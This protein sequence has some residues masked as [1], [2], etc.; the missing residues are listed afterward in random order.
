MCGTEG[1]CLNQTQHDLLLE[2]HGPIGFPQSQVQGKGK[3]RTRKTK[4]KL[5]CIWFG[6]GS[7]TTLS[8]SGRVQTKMLPDPYSCM[9]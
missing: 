5:N 7:A 4:H 3:E 2:H 9:V 1:G 6:L 8:G